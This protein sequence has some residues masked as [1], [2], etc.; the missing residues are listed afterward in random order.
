MNQLPENPMDITDLDIDLHASVENGPIDELGSRI[1]LRRKMKRLKLVQ[2]AKAA[3]ISP[4][5]LSQIE[6]GNS[7]PSIGKLVLLCK[8]LGM[9]ISWLFDDGQRES[10]D[11]E[12]SNVV[13]RKA[14]RRHVNF[15][16][17]GMEKDMLTPDTMP[18]IQM[19]RVVLKADG[20]TGEAPYN[21][22]EGAKCGLVLRGSI[23]LEIDGVA[24]HLNAGDSFAFNATSLTRFWGNGEES[25]VIWA[26][27]PAF[28]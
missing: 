20:T 8:A 19:M 10:V 21:E 7:R 22:N 5:Q 17:S 16:A 26:C 23:V 25:E 2:V 12:E 9:P 14:N 11:A 3:G 27:S 28:Y 18:G 15:P 6:R 24:H 13:V 1:R 4:A